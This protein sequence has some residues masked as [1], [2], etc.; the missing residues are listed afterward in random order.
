M[1]AYNFRLFDIKPIKQESS[2]TV[3]VK[4]II[5]NE[6]QV[7]NATIS[8]NKQQSSKEKDVIT[9]ETEQEAN[10]LSEVPPSSSSTSATSDTDIEIIDLDSDSEQTPRKQCPATTSTIIERPSMPAKDIINKWLPKIKCGSCDSIFQNVTL[11]EQHFDLQHPG[12]PMYI[13][14]CSRLIALRVAKEH[15]LL[16]KNPNAFKCHLC[17]RRYGSRTSLRTHISKVHPAHVEYYCK[18]CGCMNPSYKDQ[19][20]HYAKRHC[21]EGQPIK[22]VKDSEGRLKYPCHI[23]EH[24]SGNILPYFHHYWFEHRNLKSVHQCTACKQIINNRSKHECRVATKRQTMKLTTKVSKDFDCLYCAEAFETER[25]VVEHLASQHRHIELYTCPCCQ[26]KFN[27]VKEIVGHRKKHHPTEDKK[28]YYANMDNEFEKLLNEYVA[29]RD[30][31]YKEY[32][33]DLIR[34]RD[35]SRWRES[36]PQRSSVDKSNTK[37]KGSVASAPSEIMDLSDS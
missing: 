27:A 21:V 2:D 32:V 20:I 6:A 35:R 28:K 31:T 12:Q 26:Q 7:D 33:G 9:T 13:V 11:L 19:V 1:L 24:M 37:S 3:N 10:I 30:N 34:V 8:S 4:S 18:I 15:A 29:K 14:C 17:T 5:E 23:C 16:H 25:E 22:P 36:T